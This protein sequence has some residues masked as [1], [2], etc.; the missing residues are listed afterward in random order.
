MEQRNGMNYEN[1]MEMGKG[2]WEVTGTDWN[3]EKLIGR[4]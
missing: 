1:E 2:D 3:G 4:V